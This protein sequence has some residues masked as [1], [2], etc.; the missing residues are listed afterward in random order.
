[1]TSAKAREAITKM[2][3]ILCLDT[4]PKTTKALE[5][6]GHSV[7]ASLFGYSVGY[8]SLTECPQDF[9]LIV[10]DMRHPACFDNFKWGPYGGNDNYR[11]KVVPPG[12]VTWETRLVQYGVTGTPQEEFRYR[13]IQESQI[14][15]MNKPSPFGPKDVLNAI[16]LAG[17]PAIIFL[18][19]EWLLRAGG[20]FPNFIGMV[21]QTA[22]VQSRKILIT[23]SFTTLIQGRQP[24][25][26]ISIP[27]RCAITSGAR[28]VGHLDETSFYSQTLV[29]DKAHTTLGQALRCGAGPVWLIPATD[30]NAATAV[31]LAAQ[32]DVLSEFF[33]NASTGANGSASNPQ[34][35]VFICHASEDKS[36]ADDLYQALEPKVR[37]W[38]DTGILTMGDDQRKK[39]DEGLRNSRFGV[40]VLSPN[41][42]EKNWPQSELGAL[43]TL[44]NA[45]G[46]KR[47]LPIW[48]NIDAAGLRS[49]SPLLANIEATKSSDGIAA[50]VRSILAVVKPQG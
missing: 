12:D 32:A 35:D 13:L 18:N 9:D 37:V 36:Y 26:Q 40:V 14:E 20:S 5:A 3:D 31:Q 17:V 44:Q 46:R 6:A 45:D 33:A 7:V 4:D 22:S 27:V 25:I 24:P 49:Y 1:M 2:A 41:F 11:C 19:P 47:V 38:Y 34:W 29:R 43:M 16:T 30:D 15:H 48:H 50:T 28:I 23:E 8:R 39:I 42:F 21:W 10:C